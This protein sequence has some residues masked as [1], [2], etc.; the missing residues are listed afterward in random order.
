MTV[1]KK[2][3][4][5]LLVLILTLCIP[6]QVRAAADNSQELICSII[7]YF[8]YYQGAARTDYDL[9]LEQ[10]RGEDP[11]LAD[12]WSG[13]VDFWIHLNEGL[14]VRQPV[15][16]DG[17]PDD[18]SLCIVVMG[19][20]L[21]QDGSMRSELIDRLEVALASAE[22]YPNAYILCTGGGSNKTEAE[23]MARWLKKQ[24]ISEDRIIIE[25]K[26]KSTIEN[27]TYGCAMLYSDYPQVTTLGVITSDYHI[28]RS[29]LYFNTQAAL[30]AYK[31][32]T[33]PMKVVAAATCTINPK[34]PSD[35]DTQVE[36]ICILTNLEALNLSRPKL[37]ILESIH[38][39]GL[40]ECTVGEEPELL[41]SATYS[42]GYSREIT[43]DVVF[44]GIDFNADGFQTVTATYEENGI[45]KSTSMEIRFLPGEEPATEAPTETT[46]PT[47]AIPEILPEEPESSGLLVPGIIAAIC[48]LLLAVLVILKKRQA[49]KRRRPKP[50]IKLD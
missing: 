6:F 17:L 1:F 40:A 38:L 12:T 46:V 11:A 30:D 10:L 24:G 45:T 4:S 39:S 16:P 13:I 25:K 20:Y 27:A 23:Q 9:L 2:I 8:Q 19:Y 7:N 35:V 22:K 21:K 5:T 41:V 28:Y 47:E 18:D 43:E 3:L 34:A 31:L 15:L 50:V 14:D 33:V 36:G 29:C 32:D 44:S 48:L 37:S 26:A 42:N 49:K